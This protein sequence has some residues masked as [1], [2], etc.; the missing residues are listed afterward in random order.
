MPGSLEAEPE[1]ASEE[2]ERE[3]DQEAD[4][5]WAP[6]PRRAGLLVG[7]GVQESGNLFAHP[8]G[9]RVGPEGLQVRL[10]EAPLEICEAPAIGT[11]REVALEFGSLLF[12]ELSVEVLKEL[13]MSHITGHTSS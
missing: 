1:Y 9:G 2:D 13:Q 8:L 10:M 12:R 4:G 5:G 11:R 6:P 3:S 7:E